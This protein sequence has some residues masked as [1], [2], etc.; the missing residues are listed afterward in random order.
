MPTYEYECMS[1]G[2]KFEVRRSMSDNSTDVKCPKCE[3]ANP[4]R[5]FSAFATASSRGSCAPSGSS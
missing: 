3:A 1:C 5:V 2:E 4:R